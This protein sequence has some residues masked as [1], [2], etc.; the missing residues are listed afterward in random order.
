MDTGL[1]HH[2]NAGAANSLVVAV[3]CETYKF[4]YYYLTAQGLLGVAEH[5]GN[6]AL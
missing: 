6:I 5:Y 4:L 3:F 1:V 2:M